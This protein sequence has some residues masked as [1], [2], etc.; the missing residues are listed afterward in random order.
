MTGTNRLLRA[1]GRMTVAVATTG[2]T[3]QDCL[4]QARRACE[5]GADLVE[6]RADLLDGEPDAGRTARLAARL[7]AD[8]APVPVLLTV[9]SCAEGGAAELEGRAWAEHLARILDALDSLDE[10]GTAGRP[11]AVDVEIERPGA[12]GLV[13]LAH[14][15][16]LEVV[17]SFHDV[18]ATPPDEALHELLERMSRL[19]A[20]LAKIAV[21]PAGPADVARLLGVTAT[22]HE[23]REVPLATMAMG[24]AG[25]VSRLAAGVFG[26]RLVFAT[27][28]G[29]PS[30]PGQPPIEDLRHAMAL[31]GTP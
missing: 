24:E 9:R 18:A 31:L 16:G 17:L 20:D 1:D 23:A 5:A 11:A 25:A 26:S 15:A 13:D 14:R 22:A 4:D 21:M 3:E 7:G 10:A 29:A 12:A 19:G 27:A 6:L 2:A 28:G 30:A 8:C